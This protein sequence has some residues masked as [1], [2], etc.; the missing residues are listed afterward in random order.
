MKAKFLTTVAA[1]AVI[2]GLSG[3]AVAA[4][5]DLKVQTSSNASHFSLAYLN[6]T[7]VPKLEE[8]TN[9]ALSIELL[10][11]ESVVP[12]RETPDAISA[13]VLDG[14]LTSINYFSG[15]DPAFAL[16]GD[17]IAGYD[18]PEQMMEF[19]ANGGGKEMLQ[20]M[21]DAYYEGV[22][23]VGCG[24]YAREAFVSKVPIYGVEDLAGLKIRAPEGLAAD[25]F[26]RAGA[27]PV[28]LPGSETY[29]ALEKGVIDAADNSAYANNDANGMHKIAKYPLYPGI[30]SMPILQFTVS[31]EV[32]NDLSP[33]NQQALTDWYQQAYRG[34]IEATRQK[35]EELVARDKA[36]GE[37]TIIDW[38]QEERD[39]LRAIAEKAWADFAAGSDLAKETYQTHIDFMKEQGLL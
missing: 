35:D 9:G 5:R 38:P 20:K 6:E 12:R 24:S 7:W 30:H 32:W 25:V 26:K 23:V 15:K 21:H 8:M 16:M 10:P 37:L 28:S 4:D 3:S 14:D 33:E 34:L 19:C 31:K 1:I 29:G 13:G 22:Q 39:K 36:A 18:T 11:I 2:A 27:A 17:L